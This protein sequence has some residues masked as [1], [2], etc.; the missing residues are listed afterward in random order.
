MDKIVIEDF[1]ACHK[2]VDEVVQY[3]LPLK[4]RKFVEISHVVGRNDFTIFVSYDKYHFDHEIR[5]F[6]SGIVQKARKSDLGCYWKV[7][8]PIF[9]ETKN[10]PGYHFIDTFNVTF[11]AK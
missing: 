11:T 7:S 1:D 4:K 3:I 8:Q 5:Q 9:E 10:Q 6:I 2:F